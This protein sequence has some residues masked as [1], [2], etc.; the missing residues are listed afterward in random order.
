MALAGYT[1]HFRI[2]YM[3]KT[4]ILLYFT[5]SSSIQV[6]FWVWDIQKDFLSPAK[7][8]ILICLSIAL[9]TL[10]SYKCM[11]LPVILGDL[12]KQHKQTLL[13]YTK[14]VS[15]HQQNKMLKMFQNLKSY[16]QLHWDISWALA[17]EII[18]QTN[19][20]H[21]WQHTQFMSCVINSYMRLIV[22]FT[23]HLVDWGPSLTGWA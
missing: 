8:S 13:V 19:G 17:W 5:W 20:Q 16:H 22:S 23:C 9:G 4:L 7:Y 14:L 12:K 6:T 15:A 18:R 2:F 10:L 3:I 21:L 1:S 11:A